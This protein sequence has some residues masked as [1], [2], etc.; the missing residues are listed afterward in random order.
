M[1]V[2]GEVGSSVFSLGVWAAVSPA[3][4]S[5]AW[6]R[7]WATLSRLSRASWRIVCVDSRKRSRNEVTSAPVAVK[8]LDGQCDDGERSVEVLAELAPQ[9][10]V[11]FEGVVGDRQA[12]LFEMTFDVA[13][14]LASGA[15]GRGTVERA[16]RDR[17][18]VLAAEEVGDLC[19]DSANDLVKRRGVGGR[20]GGQD[21]D[22]ERKGKMC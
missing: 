20:V 13:G 8:Q 6:L 1:V 7:A 4:S 12:G 9:F 11:G 18:F 21:E 14:D 2:S 5:A 22:R 16:D 10:E 19:C 3:V 15:G 17:R